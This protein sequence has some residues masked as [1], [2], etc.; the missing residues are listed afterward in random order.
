M[1]PCLDH[2]GVLLLDQGL[3]NTHRVGGLAGAGASTQSQDAKEEDNDANEGRTQ[4]GEESNNLPHGAQVAPSSGSHHGSDSN[5]GA[6]GHWH[7]RRF[8]GS[9]RIGRGKAQVCNVSVSTHHSIHAIR[10][11][12]APLCLDAHLCLNAATVTSVL[13]ASTQAHDG[14]S[15]D[16]SIERVTKKSAVPRILGN[17]A[18]RET[19]HACCCI[20]CFESCIGHPHL[21]PKRVVGNW[22]SHCW[23]NR[24]KSGEGRAVNAFSQTKLMTA[25]AHHVA[26]WQIHAVIVDRPIKVPRGCCVWVAPASAT[27]I[28]CAEPLVECAGPIR[29]AIAG[30]HWGWETQLG[31][32]PKLDARR[33]LDCGEG[34]IGV[35]GATDHVELD[36]CSDSGKHGN[37]DG[38]LKFRI[39]WHARQWR[40]LF[41]HSYAGA[42][43]PSALQMQFFLLCAGKQPQ[44]E[45]VLPSALASSGSATPVADLFFVLCG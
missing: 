18:G 26:W 40:V 30:A 31:S 34:S 35:A 19:S 2:L 1:Q 23:S 10:D 45:L 9:G 28:C 17:I 25:V 4:D 7:H 20:S 42:C 39:L 41:V 27:T 8:R 5:G 22:T 12:D 44:A 33:H 38:D 13:G 21:V 29:I 16:C 36:L 11:L 15:R 37:E 14:S 32:Q 3:T 43:A 6:G 24:I